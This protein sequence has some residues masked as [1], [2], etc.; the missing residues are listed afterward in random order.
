MNGD[1]AD[2]YARKVARET[3]AAAHDPGPVPDDEDAP[4]PMRVDLDPASTTAWV[5][6]RGVA[7]SVTRRRGDPG[8]LVG[9][10]ATGD[11]SP[12]VVVHMMQTGD[13]LWEGTPYQ[14]DD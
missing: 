4:E 11:A 8:I 3:A 2:L 7:V 10:E 5:E 9:I 6:I 14:S 1:V 12:P 13:T